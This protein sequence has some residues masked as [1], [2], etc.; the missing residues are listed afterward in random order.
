MLVADFLSIN[1]DMNPSVIP[2]LNMPRWYGIMWALG[3]YLGYEV[4][5]R[6]YKSE[7]LPAN[8][9]DKSFMYV[10]IAGILGAR[11]GHCLFYQPDYY[12]AHP[13]EILKIWEGGLASH[14]GAFG[15]ILAVFLL[16]RKVMK[17]GMLWI[18]D[19]LVVPTALAG[20]LI[21]MGNLF[22]HEIVGSPTTSA[23]GFKFLRHDLDSGQAMQITNK[24]SA[25]EAY[26]EIASNDSFSYVWDMIPARHPAQLYEAIICLLVFGL[27]MYLF[28][29]T[30][31]GTI[32]GFLTGIF[33]ITVFGSR[34]LI[35]YIKEDQVDFEAGMTLNM[36]QILS[37]PLIL[38]GFYLV[39]VKL[40]AVKRRR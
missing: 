12:L 24:G 22:N 2:S 21:R 1:W 19:H 40:K 20:F 6:M 37:I 35:E 34:F 32:K 17:T 15:I 3:F 23:F 13:I 38:I 29:K 30:N 26:A 36:G 27:L 4:L 14:G 39:A 10:L 28:W 11:L 18:L 5:K 16:N 25:D 8:W 9:V 31:A 33:F 7:N